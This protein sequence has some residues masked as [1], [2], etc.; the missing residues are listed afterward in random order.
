MRRLPGVLFVLLSLLAVT[1]L[2][3]TPTIENDPSVQDATVYGGQRFL[4][5]RITIRNTT[6]DELGGI[7]KITLG[8]VLIYNE[9]LEARGGLHGRYVDEIEVVRARDNRVLGRE[10]DEQELAVFGTAVDGDPAA[11]AIAV[12]DEEVDPQAKLELEIW[13]TLQDHQEPPPGGKEIKL[14]V[15]VELEGEHIID[16]RYRADYDEA[17]AAVFTVGDPA[18]FEV[19]DP[20]PLDGDAVFGGQEFLAQ[21][22]ELRDDDDDL[23]DVFINSLI[24]ANTS[25]SDRLAE[26]HVEKIE[27]RRRS[28]GEK[29]G[30]VEGNDIRGLNAGGVRITTDDFRVPDDTG[31]VLQIWVTLGDDPPMGRNLRLS[32]VVWHTEGGVLFSTRKLMGPEFS[33]MTP[34][35]LVGEDATRQSGIAFSGHRFLAQRI[36]LAHKH[37]NDPHDVRITEIRVKNVTT[38]ANPVWDAHV[39]R[40]EVRR[41][42]DTLVGRTTNVS[43]LRRDGVSINTDHVVEAGEEAFLKIWVTLTEDAPSG[44][45]ILL[46]TAIDHRSDG[47]VFADQ[48]AVRVT[49]QAEYST[50]ELDFTWHPDEPG[51]DEE[52]TFSPSD[53]IMDADGRVEQLEFRWDFGDGTRVKTTTGPEAVKHTY[54]E[55][56]E[57]S[58]ELTVRDDTWLEASKSKT[59]TL[60]NKP[61]TGVDFSWTP[62]APKWDDEVTFSPSDGIED[63]DGNITQAEFKWEFGDGTTETTTGP[64]DV[65]HV[66]G[67]ADEFTVTLTVTDQGGASSS[68]DNVVEVANKPPVG[69]DFTWEPVEP[70]WNDRI[71]FSP[72]DDIEDPDGDVGRAEFA[73]DFGDGT[74]ETTVGP[75]DVQHV[76][77]TDGE[78]TVTLT[79]TDQGGASASKERE[80]A[81]I[82]DPPTNVDFTWEPKAP[83]WDQEITFIPGED[84]E[85]PHGDIG[86]AE[87]AWNFGDGTPATITTGPQEVNHSYVEPGTYTVTLTVTDE[88]G[89]SESKSHELTVSA[90][91]VSFSWSATEPRVGQDVTF[92]AEVEAPAPDNDQDPLEF[93]WEFGDGATEEGE[94]LF[95]VTHAYDAEATYTVQLTVTHPDGVGQTTE[96]IRVAEWP[97]PA[98]TDLEAAP[99]APEVDEEVTFTAEAEAP[100]DDPVVS[101]EWDFGDGSDIETTDTDTVTHRFARSAVFTV[102]ARARNERGGWSNWRSLDLYVRKPGAGEIGTQ[103]V[104]NPVSDE[105]RIRILLPRGDSSRLA[106]R[107]VDNTEIRIYDMLGRLVFED[108]VTGDEVRWDLVDQRRNQPVSN[109]VYFYVITA[110]VDDGVIRSDAGRIMVIRR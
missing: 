77:Q 93:L 53:A 74:T 26:Q 64:A 3:A 106:P 39:D 70:K 94:D 86:R 105:A 48:D 12:G 49:S 84:I 90:L 57:F 24:V 14:G 36:Q 89:A 41:E 87:F 43:G 28:D 79:V 40:I 38:S 108:T 51:W 9:L 11:V 59:I 6:T 73:W 33:T 13:I 97:V 67:T 55:G 109:G 47:Y 31:V 34:G 100:D 42:D 29:L 83:R 2:G 104:Q 78:F 72:S 92:T 52:V 69:V 81:V 61:P 37:P 16:D 10:R 63:P 30:E 54:G 25:T 50:M 85:D 22:I 66:Y 76:F 68:K 101:W 7:G 46:E 4:A 1:T 91:M 20:R 102:R 21:E 71:T 35:G 96:E 15:Q 19:E 60:A 23:Y 18:G 75:E 17:A 32:T 8:E 103:L 98:V 58:V 45:S 65:Q 62:V 5:Q 44:R 107:A 82:N 110:T 56:G 27:I 99:K 88:G 95:E 80:I